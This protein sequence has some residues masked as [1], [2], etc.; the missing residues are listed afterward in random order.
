MFSVV[1]YAE[2][3]ASLGERLNLDFSN[4]LF[5]LDHVPL[6][7][8][9]PDHAEQRADVARLIAE[10]RALV[11]AA[12]PGIVAQA[13]APMAVPGRHDLLTEVVVPASII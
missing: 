7:L 10:R 12:I 9:G 2:R 8:D 4:I 3:Y 11:A 5:T 6:C 13:F 1:P